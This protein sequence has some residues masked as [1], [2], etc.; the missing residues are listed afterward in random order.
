MAFFRSKED[1]LEEREMLRIQRRVFNMEIR[2]DKGEFRAQTSNDFY[3]KARI[4]QEFVN[5]DWRLLGT[6]R[7]NT[8]NESE[9][10]LRANCN[11]LPNTSVKATVMDKN[12]KLASKFKDSE[13]LLAFAVKNGPFYRVRFARRIEQVEGE[14]KA[15]FDPVAYKLKS[16]SLMLFHRGI[17]DISAKNKVVKSDQNTMKTLSLNIYKEFKNLKIAGQATVINEDYNWILSFRKYFAQS[18]LTASFARHNNFSLNYVYQMTS[19]LQLGCAFNK[20][21]SFSLKLT[22]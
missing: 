13:N 9:L 8:L 20:N 5:V 14:V 1:A 21:L 12:W 16:I 15:S 22:L 17:V 10:S 18:Y 19:A 4:F 11:D 6:L 2:S 7:M 3:A